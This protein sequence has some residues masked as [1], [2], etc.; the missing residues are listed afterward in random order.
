LL[1]VLGTGNTRACPLLR[2][3]AGLEKM[4]MKLE[5]LQAQMNPSGTTMGNLTRIMEVR[6]I[7]MFFSLI[8]LL[9]IIVP[10]CV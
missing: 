1:A 7:F 3:G 8:L 6:H 10:L 5:D 4:G 9:F 2:F